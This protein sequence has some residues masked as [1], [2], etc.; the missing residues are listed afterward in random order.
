MSASPRRLGLLLGGEAL[1]FACLVFA[2]LDR[3]AH[4][5]DV[6]FGV[7]QWGYRHDARGSKEPGERRIAVVG[8]SS[9]FEAG[10]S[11]GL[12]MAG[13][14][15]I[16]L[17]Q[18]GAQARQEYSV[19]NLSEPRAGADTYVR[20]LR[21]YAFLDPDVVLVADGYDT[22]SGEPPHGRDRSLVF[23]ATGYLPI[24]PAALLHRPAWLSDPDE[25]IAAI[26]RDESGAPDD[27]S[28][29]GASASYCASMA[30]TV[31]AAQAAGHAVAVVS[32]PTV[33][34]RQG[35][36]QRS[37]GDTLTR[38]FG[39]DPRFLYLDLG[40][41]VDLSDRVHSPDGIHRSDVGNHVVAQR[42]A[43]AIL[44]WPGAF[45]RR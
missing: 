7:N 38:A 28:C 17:R 34:K 45:A 11:Y 2:L 8:G 44:A 40:Q 15:F 21:D 41:S 6:I 42:I 1:I 30:D 9:A 36:Q 27:V 16:E 5:R 12:T 24:L 32:L 20:T 43:H 18:A 14:L 23:R 19:V 26:L 35:R 29:E 25:G 3:R 31:R 22:L 13:Q 39:G 10:R 4:Q 33:S 37:L